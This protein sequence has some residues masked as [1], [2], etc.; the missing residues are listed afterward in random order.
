MPCLPNLFFFSFFFFFYQRLSCQTTAA[1]WWSLCNRSTHRTGH[2]L[3]IDHLHVC[4]FVRAGSRYASKITAGSKGHVVC[5]LLR[6]GSRYASTTISAS[7]GHVVLGGLDPAFFA[8]VTCATPHYQTL[9][10]RD[11][12]MLFFFFRQIFRSSYSRGIFVPKKDACYDRGSTFRL[13]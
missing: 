10:E 4:F 2:D 3:S 6:A 11:R 1:G 8:H 12:L 13:K 7:N 5:F 9:T